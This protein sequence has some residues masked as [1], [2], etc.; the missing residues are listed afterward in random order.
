MIMMKK[1]GMYLFDFYIGIIIFEKKES[2]VLNI[3][4]LGLVESFFIFSFFQLFFIRQISRQ[5]DINLKQKRLKN[6]ATQ[7]KKKLNEAK[8]LF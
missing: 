3:S 6:K 2:N 4:M 1:K 5:V 7:Q 8:L